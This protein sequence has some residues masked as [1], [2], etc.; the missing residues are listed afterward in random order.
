MGFA[1]VFHAETSATISSSEE[2][3]GDPKLN[4]M[5]VAKVREGDELSCRNAPLQPESRYRIVGSEISH[6]T[7]GDPAWLGAT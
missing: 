6:P 7:A 5:L 4:A 2:S 1:P 3:F